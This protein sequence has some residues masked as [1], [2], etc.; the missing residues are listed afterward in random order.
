MEKFIQLTELKGNHPEKFST[1]K[2]IIISISKIAYMESAYFVGNICKEQLEKIQ[3]D[4]I[5][6]S[7]IY[8][9]YIGTHIVLTDR[10]KGEPIEFFVV[11]S[12]D[13]CLNIIN[14]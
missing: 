1:G 12:P 13:T 14:N 10:K 9:N 11:E 3:N 4:T 8:S 7:A 2:Q 5:R 6:D